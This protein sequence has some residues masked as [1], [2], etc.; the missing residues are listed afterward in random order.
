[1][2]VAD[3]DRP[4][5]HSVDRVLAD[6]CQEIVPAL[7]LRH[8]PPKTIPAHLIAQTLSTVHI[9]ERSGLPSAVLGVGAAKSGWLWNFW[10][11]GG[12]VI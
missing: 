10:D 11:S 4:V 1:L 6:A 8:Q 2:R 9:P 5:V 3:R 7:D 12:R